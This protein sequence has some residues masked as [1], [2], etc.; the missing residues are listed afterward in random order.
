MNRRIRSRMYGGVRG[1]ELKGS[2]LLDATTSFVKG[3][4][5][6]TFSCSGFCKDP[7]FVSIDF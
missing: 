3:A 2:P 1:R 7:E 5:I 6:Y 4:D